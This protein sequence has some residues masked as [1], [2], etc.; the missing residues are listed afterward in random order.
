M[1]LTQ[2]SDIELLKNELNELSE[3]ML[4]ESV[5]TS[6]MRR[7]Q[8]EGKLVTFQFAKIRRIHERLDPFV[9]FKQPY[10]KERKFEKITELYNHV[11]AEISKRL[12]ED[13]DTKTP[14]K[15]ATSVISLSGTL[16]GNMI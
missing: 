3:N 8:L 15:A 7:K 12:Q 11:V 6:F 16:D 14:R 4:G 1:L 5:A 9:D 10:W 2:K 13:P